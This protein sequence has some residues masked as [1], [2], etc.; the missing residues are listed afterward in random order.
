MEYLTNSIR[1]LFNNPSTWIKMGMQGRKHV[2]KFHDVRKEVVTLE[3]IYK[4]VLQ[5]ETY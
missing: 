5:S 4:K 3:K 2:E 1:Y